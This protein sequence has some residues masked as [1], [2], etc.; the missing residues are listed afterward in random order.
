MFTL[1]SFLKITIVCRLL[2]Y[3]FHSKSYVGITFV[4]KLDWGTIWAI[5]SQ[6]NPVTL[7][8]NKD[9]CVAKEYFSGVIP[10]GN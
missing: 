1:G 8:V 4:K 10:G 9:F 3:F 2:G 5:F 6:T 7:S